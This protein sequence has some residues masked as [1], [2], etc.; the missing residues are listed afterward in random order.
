MTIKEL[1]EKYSHEEIFSKDTDFDL[2][3][4]IFKPIFDNLYEN[5]VV[6]HNKFTS[7][8]KIERV[9]IRPDY[10]NVLLIPQ[11]YI[12]RGTFSD[13]RIKRASEILKH[14]WEVG[15]IWE[16][17]SFEEDCLC[18]S[19]YT[20]WLMWTDPILVKKVESLVSENKF[21]EALNLTSNKI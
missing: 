16:L 18:S 11:T 10:L 2:R 15:C 6:I 8:A 13:K 9:E 1:R 20:C 17:M 3:L 14:G 19:P 5:K 12:P 4:K 21:E 7:I